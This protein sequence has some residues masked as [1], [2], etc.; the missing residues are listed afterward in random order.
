MLLLLIVLVLALLLV[1]D[2]P[3]R[4][5]VSPRIVSI[6]CSIFSHDHS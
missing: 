4:K 3:V 2:L 6:Q 1:L 5:H